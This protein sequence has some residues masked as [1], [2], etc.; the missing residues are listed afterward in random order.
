MHKYRKK[1]P[2]KSA[3]NTSDSTP[4]SVVIQLFKN[5][6][7]ELE[8]KQ[9]RHERLVKISRDITVESKRLIFFLH[10]HRRY[11]PTWIFDVLYRK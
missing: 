3:E 5:F 1:P 2:N 7:S 11:V 9:D 10:S 8:E 6:A 4:T